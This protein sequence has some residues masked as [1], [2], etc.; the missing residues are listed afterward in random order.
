MNDFFTNS[1]FFGV[2]L[3]LAAYGIGCLL[4]KKFKLAIFNPLLIAIVLVILFLCCFHIDYDT[5]NEGAM[6]SLSIVVSGIL[7]VIGASL[8]TQIL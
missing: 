5:Y 8:V 2:V 6:S 1:V 4:K 3:S 7:T